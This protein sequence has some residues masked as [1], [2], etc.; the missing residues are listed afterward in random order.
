MVL[1]FGEVS[2]L[3]IFSFTVFSKE[4]NAQPCILF[5][6]VPFR[7]R[8]LYTLLNELYTTPIGEVNRVALYFKQH[9][10]LGF[11]DRQW[12]SARVFAIL[13]HRRLLEALIQRDNQ[14]IT[15]ETLV[16]SRR[17]SFR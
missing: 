4:N 17:R 12:I 11:K 5:S 1:Y 16:T 6:T 9:R 10:S 14:E 8:H 2:T 15:P 7:L 13:R 3:V